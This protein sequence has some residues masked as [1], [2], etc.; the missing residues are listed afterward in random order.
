MPR[1]TLYLHHSQ[2][3]RENIQE[4]KKKITELY[5]G[6]ESTFVGTE[7]KMLLRIFTR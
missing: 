3:G 6:K 5:L 4:L 1:T 2:Q 7:E